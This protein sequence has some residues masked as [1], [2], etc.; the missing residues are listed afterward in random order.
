MKKLN[1]DNLIF[2]NTNIDIFVNNIIE[3]NHDICKHITVN[4]EYN[5][6]TNTKSPEFRER[7]IELN[8]LVRESISNIL[9][10]I[11]TEDYKKAI[12]NETI[13]EDYKKAI[14]N[15]TIDNA[16][17]LGLE[18]FNKSEFT[19][20]IKNIINKVKFTKNP[21]KWFINLFKS[22]Y[23]IFKEVDEK[24]II[25]NIIEKIKKL[26]YYI[27]ANGRYGIG[28]KILVNNRIGSMLRTNPNFVFTFSDDV[29]KQLN[30]QIYKIG[31]IYGI[32]I[33]INTKLDFDNNRI[34]IWRK[35]NDN[36]PGLNIV[37][38]PGV[39][40][41]KVESFQH[42]S[43]YGLRTKNIKTYKVF[44]TTDDTYKQF[45]TLDLNIPKKKKFKERFK[46]RFKTFF[47]LK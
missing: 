7:I 27:A 8:K 30:S 33:Y 28:D 12:L 16:Y 21:F 19:E 34:L 15:E 22:E 2:E 4:F 47:K 6:D 25:D 35:N 14:L 31:S 32:E 45:F 10:D 41:F 11:V 13:A 1:I 29:R 20:D 43:M 3:T 18:N 36:D 39:E 44:E 37:H 42:E 26:S 9:N 40:S 46:E 24:D 17:H 38:K 23:R 5:E